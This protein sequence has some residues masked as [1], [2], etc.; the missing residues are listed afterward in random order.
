MQQ[1]PTDVKFYLATD[2][3]EVK[4]EMRYIFGNR[5]ITSPNKATRGNLEGM[6]DAL[7]EMYLLAT[8]DR[9]LGSSCSTYSMTAA[10]I[11]RVPLEIIE[12]KNEDSH[13]YRLL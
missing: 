10:S 7:V 13:H 9:I 5:I 8:T 6:E 3:E 1:E 4:E 2:S 11:G 12:K